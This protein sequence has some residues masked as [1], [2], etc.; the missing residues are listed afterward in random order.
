MDKSKNKK[1]KKYAFDNFESKLNDRNPSQIEKDLA[2]EEFNR[3]NR[4]SHQ[5]VDGMPDIEILDNYNCR[6]YRCGAKFNLAKVNKIRQ[7]DLIN[8]MNDIINQYKIFEN[9]DNRENIEFMSIL[10]ESINII[11]MEYNNLTKDGHRS[12]NLNHNFSDNDVDIDVDIDEFNSM[13]KKL[14]SYDMQLIY[15]LMCRLI[16]NDIK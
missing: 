2:I 12:R 7:F 14:S 15:N 8:T 9:K 13:L 1:L 10:N 11:I 16:H 6:C 4:C 5:R 3:K